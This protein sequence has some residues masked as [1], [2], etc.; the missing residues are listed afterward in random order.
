VA[1]ISL[2]VIGIGTTNTGPTEKVVLGLIGLALLL[3]AYKV[4]APRRTRRT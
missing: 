4:Q 1:M 2:V 3:A